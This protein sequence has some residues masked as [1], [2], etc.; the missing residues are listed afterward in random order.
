MK[1]NLALRP[2]NALT[3]LHKRKKIGSENRMTFG[4]ERKKRKLKNRHGTDT[5]TYTEKNKMW[6]RLSI[7]VS[8]FSQF[9]F[10]ASASYFCYSMFWAPTFDGIITTVGGV[11]FIALL[12]VIQFLTSDGFWDS[13]AEGEFNISYF[14]LNFIVIWGLVAAIAVGGT[15]LHGNDNKSD[16]QMFNNPNVAAIRA[17][18]QA[19]KNSIASLESENNDLSTDSQYKVKS[20]KDKGVVRHTYQKQISTNKVSISSLVIANTKLAESLL[21][22]YGVSAGIDTP[23]ATLNNKIQSSKIWMRVGMVVILLMA[24]EKARQYKSKYD[25]VKYTEMVLAGEMEDE[26]Y[27]NLLIGKK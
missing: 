17:D 2:E 9:V 1:T 14:V 27:Y 5:R 24:F 22:Q 23:N 18:I 3:I 15:F 21:T 11:G 12:A 6:Q 20:G 4:K 13:M 16:P 19:N 8:Y 26:D 25:R 10:F 7:F